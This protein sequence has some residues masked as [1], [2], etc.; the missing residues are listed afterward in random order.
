M[1]S[2]PKGLRVHDFLQ[3][4]KQIHLHSSSQRLITHPPPMTPNVEGNRI[5]FVVSRWSNSVFYP[6]ECLVDILLKAHSSVHPI[7]LNNPF[8]HQ[9]SNDPDCPPLTVFPNGGLI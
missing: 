1:D 7:L 6:R 4:P 2:T 9:A 5:P 3:E 8:R